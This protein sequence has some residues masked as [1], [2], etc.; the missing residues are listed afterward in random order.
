MFVIVSSY[1]AKVGEEDA[2]IALH[3]DW[4]RSQGLKRPR[5]SFL[6][7]PQEDRGSPRVHRDRT[8]RERGD[9]AGSRNRT[10]ARR[11]ALPSG[12]PDRGGTCSHGLHER[13]D[14]TQTMRSCSRCQALAG[15]K[16]DVMHSPTVYTL[17]ETSLQLQST[18]VEGCPI[19]V[20]SGDEDWLG[21]RDDSWG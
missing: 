5:L 2:I 16:N 15:C 19:E 10:R 3:E 4:Q 1:R 21:S 13:M 7:T 8:L 17:G 20:M 14:V 12:E 11:L 9:G 6:G 18:K